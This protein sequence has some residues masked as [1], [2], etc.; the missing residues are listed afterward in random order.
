MP[1]TTSE[2][3]DHFVGRE[4]E[5]ALLDAFL[6]STEAPRAFVLVGEPGIGKTFLW[7]AGVG[8]ARQR[9]LRVLSARGSGAETGLSFGALIDLLDRVGS[10]ELVGLPPPQRQ[11]LE[12]AL[13][14]AESTGTTPDAQAIAVGFL[15]TLRSLAGREAVLVAV[16]DIQWLDAASA[17]ALAFAARRLE[18][19]PVLFLLARR[20]GSASSVERALGERVATSLEVR[21]LSIGAIRRILSERFALSLPRHVLRRVY[22]STLGNPLFAL[23]L[24]RTLAARGAPALTEDLPLPDAVEDLLGTRVAGLDEPVREVLLALALQA[25]L[26]AGQL[27]AIAGATALEDA[28]DAGVILV[29]GDHARPAHPLLAAVAKT[30]ARARNRR[31]LH[32]KLAG[33]ARDGELRALHLALAT[34]LP[35]EGLAATAA[36]AAAAAS[37]RGAARQA[38]VLA[39]HALRLTPSDSDD[40]NERLL[41]LAGYLEVAG[42]R[43]RVTDLLTPEVDALPRRDRVR[44]WLR[45]S[46][47]GAIESNHD[48]IG[49]LDLALAASEDDAELR[50]FVLAKKAALTPSAVWRIP[51]AEAWSL[52]A[53]PAARAA[54]P[55]V[56]RLALHALA[57]ARAMRGQPIDDI[58]D[59]FRAASPA[60]AHITDSPEP[61]EALRLLWRGHVDEARTML[62][63]FLALADARGEEVSYALQRLNLCDLELRA[64][65]WDAAEHLL[66]EWRS[67]DRQLLIAATYERS[68]ALLAAGRGFPEEAERLASSSLAG[69]EP[70]GYR[71]QVLEALRA[72]GIAA[73]IAAEPARAAESLAAVWQHMQSEGV[74]EPGAFPVAPDLVEALVELGELEEA[75]RVAE[76][77]RRLAEEQEHPWGLASAKRCSALIRLSSG[78]FDEAAAT[79]LADAADGYRRA[80]ASLRRHALPLRSRTGSTSSEE[81]GGGT[82]LARAGRGRVRRAGLARLGGAGARRAHARRRPPAGATAGRADPG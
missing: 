12:A 74:D 33:V 16:D 38:V 40:R 39:E 80:G 73:L 72:R 25:D 14:R 29:E 24:G 48:T 49:Y 56:E 32:L 55:S 61:V 65:G 64:G 52:E 50:A 70:Y 66:D 41:E 6:A 19:E 15:N 51:E 42:E 54:G 34:E 82:E 47:G 8:A 68:R 62:T 26:R 10:E 75:R 4:S 21:P 11:A 22:E 5:W 35:D 30:H 78:S 45:L 43:Q 77:L 31:A 7:E 36:A 81:V 57:W 71:W 1:E 18:A 13:L 44:A 27:T 9:G 37:A 3:S 2:R 20:P 63:R 60:A 59:R 79:D 28:V 58:C 69:S 23:E 46:E 67:A 53:M 76:R 17:D